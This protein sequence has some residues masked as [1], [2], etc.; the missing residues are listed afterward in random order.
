MG[1]RSQGPTSGINATF[2]HWP[3]DETDEEIA[4]DL[5]EVSWSPQMICSCS[6]LSRSSTCFVAM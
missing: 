6:P 5:K 1:S 4:A 3:G 2:G